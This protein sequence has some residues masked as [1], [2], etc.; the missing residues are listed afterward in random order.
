[1]RLTSLSEKQYGILKEYLETGTAV[2]VT[3]S[4]DPCSE[5]IVFHYGNSTLVLLKVD[6]NDSAKCGLEIFASTPKGETCVK[7]ELEQELG[8]ELFDVS[9]DQSTS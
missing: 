1:M 6:M 2:L 7:S 9:V 3:H 5:K 8:S 4:E